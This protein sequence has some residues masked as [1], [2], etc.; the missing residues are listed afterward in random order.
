MVTTLF[1]LLH[2]SLSLLRLHPSIFHYHSS[3]PPFFPLPCQS[4]VFS[5]QM[6]FH[7]LGNNDYTKSGGTV[8]DDLSRDHRD[9]LPLLILLYIM[10]YSGWLD[11]SPSPLMHLAGDVCELFEGRNGCRQDTAVGNWV[12]WWWHW[13][14]CRATDSSCHNPESNSL[15][16]CGLKNINYRRRLGD[17]LCRSGDIGSSDWSQDL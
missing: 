3:L 16:L 15:F 13:G 4:R 6:I 14:G 17:L 1:C 7:Q 10:Q 8:S 11:S 12:K 2:L 9:L 5:A